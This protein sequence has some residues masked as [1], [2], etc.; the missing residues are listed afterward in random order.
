MI[1][2]KKLGKGYWIAIIFVISILIIA[3]CKKTASQDEPPFDTQ[4]S[5]TI[6]KPGNSKAELT[7]S[8]TI[9]SQ[10][11]LINKFVGVSGS[12]GA[13]VG[14]QS[15]KIEIRLSTNDSLLNTKMITTF[16][17]KDY[18]VMNDI[19]ID[20]PRSLRG[21]IYKVT[22]TSTDLSGAQVGKKSFYA[23]D[24]LI[25]GPEPSC[26]VANQV[27]FL[28]ETPATTLPTDNIYLFGSINGYNNTD[29]TWKLTP[30]A[31]LPNCYC[32]TLPFAP[33]SDPWQLQEIFITRGSY[34]SNCVLLNGNYFGVNYNLPDPNGL[35]TGHTSELYKIR[36]PKWRD[37]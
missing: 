1:H 26:V 32:I 34:A 19:P 21:K 12:S 8:D 24:V 13:T 30:S 36:I 35:A 10:A 28:I 3:G 11:G 20:I 16:F 15:I 18:H 4:N 7:L 27:T 33:G 2:T 17:R 22:V 37:R 6:F 5:L 23:Q 31:D 25:C 9:L 14:L 29:V